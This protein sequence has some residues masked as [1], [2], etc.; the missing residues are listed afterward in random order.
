MRLLFRLDAGN[1]DLDSR[2]FIRPSVRGIIIRDRK[3]AMVHSRKFDYFKFPGGGIESGES[4]EQTLI[5]EVLEE[6][7]LCVLP[8]TIQEFGLVSRIEKGEDNDI[9]IQDNFYYLCHTASGTAAQQLDDYE[10]AERFTMEWVD[11]VY[12]IETNRRPDHGPK[13]PT[14][15]EREARVLEVLIQEGYFK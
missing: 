7:G 5:R 11:P 10:A 1:Y 6:A 14:M 4:R 13:N 12:A 15:I 3:I 2:K 9:F 8:D